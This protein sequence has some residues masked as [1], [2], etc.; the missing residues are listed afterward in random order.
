MTSS[1][2]EPVAGPSDDDAFVRAHHQLISRRL[3]L[4]A[5]GWLGLGI[6][7]R[8][9]LGRPSGAGTRAGAAVAGDTNPRPVVGHPRVSRRSRRSAPVAGRHR[10]A[11]R[12]AGARSI[13]ITLAVKGSTL[14]LEIA[15]DGGGFQPEMQHG[16]ESLGLIGMEERA[17]ALGGRLELDSAPGPGTSVRLGCPIVVRAPASA[18]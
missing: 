2:S 3:P 8:T 9:G 10:N 11:V 4:F 16:G 13:Q 7:L 17:L 6:V 14:A 15:D 18:A 5:A 1:T 12:H